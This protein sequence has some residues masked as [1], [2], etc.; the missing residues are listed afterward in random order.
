MDK[1]CLSGFCF[2]FLASCGTLP[3]NSPFTAVRQDGFLLPEME[4]QQLTFKSI[5]K[6][7]TVLIILYVLIHLAF[8][9]ALLG[10]Y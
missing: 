2:D 1:H 4:Q 3:I 6:A 10:R 9:A 8:T 5:H 7:R